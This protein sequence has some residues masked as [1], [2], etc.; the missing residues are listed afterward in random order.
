MGNRPS[1]LTEA[2]KVEV[3]LRLAGYDNPT[4]IA[5]SLKEELGIDIA[6][7]SIALYD[8][9]TYRGRQCPA[10]WETLFHETRA[11]IIAGLS[12]V[13]AAYKMVRVRWLDQMARNE[14][15]ASNSAEARALIKQAAEETGEGVTHRHEHHGVFLHGN[16][17]ETELD[18]RL[19]AAGDRLAAAIA[20]RRLG[21]GSAGPGSAGPGS[22]G[23]G[24]GSGALAGSEGERGGAQPPDEPLPG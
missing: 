12:D 3:V 17:S 14:I 21:P 16:L 11:K 8:P 7:S 20:A 24:S 19:T 4:A 10:R 5:R 18:A 6:V 1:K 23:S 22:A 9:T 13:G 2:L 15:A